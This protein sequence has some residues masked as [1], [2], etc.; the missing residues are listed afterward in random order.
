MYTY[1]FFSPLSDFIIIII[2]I[3]FFVLF[4]RF[5]DRSVQINPRVSRG[6][7]VCTCSP[8]PS[9]TIH[10]YLVKSRLAREPRGEKERLTTHLD[11]EKIDVRRLTPLAVIVE[12]RVLSLFR[13]FFSVCLSLWAMV[14]ACICVCV[15]VCVCMCL[16]VRLQPPSTL[17]NPSPAIPPP[18]TF[19]LSLSIVLRHTLTG[20]NDRFSIWRMRFT[21]IPERPLPSLRSPTISYGLLPSGDLSRERPLFVGTSGI[22]GRNGEARKRGLSG[23]NF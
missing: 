15:W 3:S 8:P 14:C 10:R 6:L 12:L 18:E 21:L 2:I 9:S 20:E 13:F 1:I 17:T 4:Q 16:C 7:V 5:A 23:A 19:S 11:N 22:P